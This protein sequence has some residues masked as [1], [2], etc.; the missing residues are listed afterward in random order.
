[1]GGDGADEVGADV[2]RPEG[3]APPV[4]LDPPPLP[5]PMPEPGTSSGDPRGSK[6]SRKAYAS[7]SAR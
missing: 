2:D 1:M 4:P 5:A 6:E 3:I 7:G